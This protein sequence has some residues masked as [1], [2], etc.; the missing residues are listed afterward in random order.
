MLKTL[1]PKRVTPIATPL[2][3][4]IPSKRLFQIIDHYIEKPKQQSTTKVH[5]K[6]IN[7]QLQIKVRYESFQNKTQRKQRRKR[8]EEEQKRKD[9][10]EELDLGDDHSCEKQLLQRLQSLQ[11]SKKKKIEIAAMPSDHRVETSSD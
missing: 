7:P 1:K 10:D 8:V 3:S 2:V 4:Q 11:E 9:N 6:P 5:R